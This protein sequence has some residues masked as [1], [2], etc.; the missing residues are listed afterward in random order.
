MEQ[1][2]SAPRQPLWEQRVGGAPADEKAAGWTWGTQGN[3]NG[4]LMDSLVTEWEED[5]DSVPKLHRLLR[6]YSQG[7]QNRKIIG[8]SWPERNIPG[9]RIVWAVQGTHHKERNATDAEGRGL[10][11]AMSAALSG[12]RI[13]TST[14]GF[15]RMKYQRRWL[16]DRML[17]MYWKRGCVCH[18][19]AGFQNICE[20]ENCQV[21]DSM[22]LKSLI[23]SGSP[24]TTSCG[25]K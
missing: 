7:C 9:P 25:G 6:D 1:G 4:T 3:P 8:L 16:F 18:E 21:T 17:E 2:P 12:R 24:L 20:S 23:T 14:C 11:M 13:P 10:L 19:S 5:R 15:F 22:G